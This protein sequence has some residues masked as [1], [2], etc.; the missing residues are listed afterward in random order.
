LDL[1]KCLVLPANYL[2]KDGR[3][4]RDV[5][6]TSKTPGR[7]SRAVDVMPDASP[8]RVPID[9]EA[10][11]QIVPYGRFA[12]PGVIAVIGNMGNPHSPAQLP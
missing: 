5:P 10:Q 3:G 11:H 1:R 8:T 2:H 12:V 9:E 4:S 6:E 7:C